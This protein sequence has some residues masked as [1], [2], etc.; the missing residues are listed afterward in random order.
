MECVAGS[1][2][3]GKGYRPTR[4]DGTPLYAQDDFD[5]LPDI[6]ERRA[7]LRIL[8]WDMEPGDAIAFSFMTVHGAPANRTGTVRRAFS[9]RWLG[10]D[11]RYAERAGNTSP[12]FPD[13]RLRQ[14]DPL[15]V[16]QFPLVH[17]R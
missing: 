10:D 17:R 4:F 14:G 11:A 5:T 9:S 8:G 13:V 16:P 1:H 3:W 7:E 12:P 2:R 6:D 15:D